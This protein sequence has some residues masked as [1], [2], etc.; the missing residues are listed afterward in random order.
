MVI[1][2]ILGILLVLGALF[3]LWCIFYEAQEET[4][5]WHRKDA[6]ERRRRK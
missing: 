4:R 2:D 5:A 3:K 1:F 6:A